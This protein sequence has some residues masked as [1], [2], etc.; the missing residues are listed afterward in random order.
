MG[1]EGVRHGGTDWAAGG[2]D[3]AAGG[4]GE[5]GGASVGSL[6]GGGVGEGGGVP[7]LVDTVLEVLLKLAWDAMRGGRAV[8][9]DLSGAAA[10]RVVEAPEAWGREKFNPPT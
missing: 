4:L 5:E 3:G 9:L 6:V 8:S 7:G 10:S 1:G 2:T